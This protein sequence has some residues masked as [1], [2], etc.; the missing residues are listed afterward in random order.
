LA[1]AI[2]SL[3]A[4]RWAS[5]PSRESIRAE[6]MSVA[7]KEGSLSAR[8]SNAPLRR[9][10]GGM[11]HNS[12]CQNFLKLAQRQADAIVGN[13]DSV[14]EDVRK[15][16]LQVRHQYDSVHHEAEQKESQLRRLREDI[17]TWDMMHGQKS[18]EEIHLAAFC[19]SLEQQHDETV[20]QIRETKTSRKVYEHML[21]RIQK[22]QAILRQKMLYME[23]HMT[24]KKREV[25]QKRGEHERA[26][27]DR[28]QVV[29][30]LEAL[31]VD[32]ELERDVCTRAKEVME[33]EL[34]RRKEANKRRA[35]FES[36]RH[37]VALQA[38]NEAFNASAGR[39]RKLYALEKLAG[40]CLQKITFEQV[41]RSQN[42][43]D[44]FQKIRDVTG[45]ADVMDIVH[46]FLNR[47]VEH[48]QLKASVKEAEVRLEALRQDFE[49]H[50]RDT[51]G[52]T[53][54]GNVGRSGNLYKE[55]EQAERRLS[56]AMEE[57]EHC[58]VRL[59]RT[60]QQ[61]EHMK[62]WA[63]RVGQLLSAFNDPVKVEN[64]SDLSLF[65]RTLENSVQ[66]YVEHVGRQISDGKITR[67]ALVQALNREFHEQARR[68]NDDQ[69][70]KTNRRVPPT[71]DARPPSQQKA[72]EEDPASLFSEERERYKKESENLAA[73]VQ[74]EQQKRQKKGSGPG[75]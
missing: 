73:K 5:K 72:G 32:A 22:E 8:S 58:R 47:D 33:G 57:H 69:F 54:D 23:D 36:W 45:L 14:V 15:T 30:D 64:P 24:R 62:R 29:Q 48:D 53:F 49:C 63:L 21:A 28:V 6:A 50:K 70:Q 27:T 52:I 19:E 75:A 68:L 1:Q 12:G 65:F 26:R 3:P 25:Q 7:V 66:R 55:I 16:L 42:T 10:M 4:C 74:A 37:E 20:R 11:S 40:N 60:M 71:L 41:E 46:K 2:S 18:D 13:D 61:V 39:L 35:D 9:S 56:D 17:R 31:E 38:A 51:E 59:Q 43:E 34:N 67:K 44:G